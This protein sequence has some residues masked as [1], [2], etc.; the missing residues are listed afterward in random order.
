MWYYQEDDNPAIDIDQTENIPSTSLKWPGATPEQLD[1]MK[2]VYD[3]NLAISDS[4]GT[5]IADTPDSQLG[6]IESGF[7]MRAEAAESCKKLFA[8]ARSDIAADSNIKVTLGL[9]SAYRSASHQFQLWQ[10]YFPD[11]YKNTTSQREAIAAGIHSEE[12]A[13]L[14]AKYIRPKIAAPGYSNHNKGLAV[15]FKNTENGI[16][17]RNK[18][19]KED[20]EK[21]QA[22]WF[23]KWLNAN[24]AQNNFY[25]YVAEPWHW[26]YRAPAGSGTSEYFSEADNYTAPYCG[27]AQ[28]DTI[29]ANVIA[30]ENIP[31][32]TTL[33]AAID[34]GIGPV[35]V[36]V[37]RDDEEVE[38]TV[39]TKK[40]TGIFIPENFK[41]NAFIDIIIYLHG[42]KS[43][44][45]ASINYYWNKKS[46]PHFILREELNAAGK[47]AI[48]VAPNLGPRSQSQTGTLTTKTGF[49]DFLESVLTVLQTNGPYR[50]TEKPV[51]RNIILA[52]HSGGGVPLR[53]IASLK[54]TGG[55]ANKIRECWCFDGLYWSG[56]AG[57]WNGWARRN[58]DA[59]L[60]VY[61]KSSTSE[62]SRD[63][64]ERS[65][66][67][68]NV[69]VEPAV[70]KTKFPTSDHNQVPVN[71]WRTL[72]SNA[73]FLQNISASPVLIPGGIYETETYDDYTESGGGTFKKLNPRDVHFLA[74]EGGGGKGFVYVG[75]IKA[76][77]DL[78]I[79]RYANG[80]LD[81]SGQIKG[82][83]GSSAGAITAML[84]MLGY[85]S[86]EIRRVIS[87]I[88][89]NR[90]FDLPAIPRHVPT[91][92]GC[93]QKTDSIIVDYI[94]AVIDA[95]LTIPGFPSLSLGK[96]ASK[97]MITTVLNTILSGPPADTAGPMV[98]LAAHPVLY[99]ESLISDFGLFSGCFT[100]NLF[101]QI[102]K[103][104][105]GVDNIT[106]SRLFEI[107]KIKLVIT[108]TNL[109]KRTVEYFSKDTTPNMPVATAVRISMSLPFG[110]KPVRITAAEAQQLGHPHLEGLWIDG[111]VKDNI[112]VRAF[113]NEGFPK[114]HTLGLRLEIDRPGKINNLY[115]YL[116][117]LAG[118]F[119][120][121]EGTVSVTSGYLEQTITFDTDGL[122]TTDFTPP[123]A[124]ID[125]LVKQAE[126]KV[127]RYFAANTNNQGESGD[128]FFSTLSGGIDAVVGGVEFFASLLGTIEYF[129]LAKFFQEGVEWL[130]RNKA[131][132]SFFSEE[133]EYN[134]DQ[135]EIPK[136]LDKDKLFDTF[137]K[138]IGTD[139]AT[140]V[141]DRTQPVTAKYFVI[142][143]TAGT[144]EPDPKS[145]TVSKS[146]VHC[147]LGISTVLLHRDWNLKGD[148]T[149]VE[150]TTNGCFVHTELTQH[151]RQ[152][153]EIKDVKAPGTAYTY[154]QYFLLA[155]AYVVA[156]LRK[157]RFL[158]V[159]LHREVDRAIKYDNPD[160]DPAKKGSPKYLSGHGDPYKF[161]IKFFYKMV[162]AIIGMPEGFTFGIQESRVLYH[163]GGNLDGQ[164][165]EFIDF[166]TGKVP[167]ANQ[168][169]DPKWNRASKSPHILDPRGLKM[170]MKC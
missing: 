9:T 104:K 113:E 8:A 12:A 51:I 141:G 6:E 144:N 93:T 81:P 95:S 158:T 10:D 128:D 89:F 82:I 130:D 88:N 66:D 83:A 109:E 26:E 1:F 19:K 32:L 166:V 106:F 152:L 45:D 96:A 108:G 67:I 69:L 140:I 59:K 165:N 65:A 129:D 49:E 39:K 87:S 159:T 110:F 146:A 101:E 114:P 29:T 153:E 58:P 80:W 31:P 62:H 170:N 145:S 119:I 162:S 13:Q 30:T 76:L 139:A 11:Y 154:R 41:G 15:D 157:G 155:F 50:E 142:H 132:K 52:A 78:K 156:S 137:I 61:F 122:S 151:P 147:W 47:N 163:N 72:I 46:N 14:L 73:S 91:A 100:R 148:A 22:S 36:K 120:N 2:R 150:T 103:G 55:Y 56:D 70:I 133:S 27:E 20:I 17:L 149:K 131:A 94:K 21:W 38:L 63:L 53:N 23:W 107:T 127:K 28:E 33:Y 54:G 40:E 164:V 115:D 18:T 57:F 86:E 71:Y 160:Y 118:T 37:K 117:A 75:G 24:A 42:I 112:P 90:F 125:P 48:L 77:E 134:I 43:S 161:D 143:D 34:L 136:W 102:L 99:G 168:Y 121:S 74:L 92:R 35:K 7:K 25:A 126:Q 97:E 111:G 60:F 84:L 105:T 124:I 167:F 116:S 135:Y 85:N 79:I 44:R 3:I 64:L 169:G 68:G 138:R 16:T 4:R 5:F 123:D 98:K